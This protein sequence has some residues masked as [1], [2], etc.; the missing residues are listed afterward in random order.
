MKKSLTTISWIVLL[1][2][3]LSACNL[4]ASTT[5]DAAATLNPLYTAAAQTLEA[6]SGQDN[7]TS[8]VPTSTPLVGNFSTST[9]TLSFATSTS[10]S[11]QSPVPVKRCDA[12]AFVKDVTIS[13]GTI[14][15]PGNSF[16][17]TWRLQNVGTCSWT[18]S[19]ALV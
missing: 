19:Y 13:D 15:G 7:A 6:M 9:P 1:A 12:A 10:Y 8:I 17:K 14:I 11:Y 5:P 18:P 3:L 4:G 16:K 2:F